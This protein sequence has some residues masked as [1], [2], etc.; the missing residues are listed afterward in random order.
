MY[1]YYVYAY[2]R[3][4][5]NTPYYIGKGKANR[6]FNKHGHI[7]VPNDKSKIVFLEKNLSEVGALA[8]ERRYIRWYGRKDLNTGVLLNRTDGGDFGFG[9]KHT[10]ETKKKLAEKGKGRKLNQKSLDKMR[11]T[12]QERYG[13]D[14][15]M[16]LKTFVE[17]VNQAKKTTLIKRYSVDHQMKIP[18]IAGKVAE[19]AKASNLEKYGVEYT[20]QLEHVQEKRLATQRKSTLDKYGVDHWGKTE[21]GKEHLRSLNEK[22]KQ[23]KITI[24][25]P[26]CSRES[27]NKS[28]MTRF[29]FDNCQQKI[30]NILS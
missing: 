25:C 6:A 3:R 20:S 28:N 1:I 4:F 5:D 29:H 10:L 17:K 7:T 24:R 9:L 30:S 23:N 12:C 16:A 15:I 27:T 13:V 26:H 18:G 14:N 19:K 11:K 22:R 2:L 8:L 21:K